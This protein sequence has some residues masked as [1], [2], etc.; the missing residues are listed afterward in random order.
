MAFRHGKGT[1]ILIGST[2]LSTYFRDTTQS[3]TVD[4]AE[5]TTYG[6]TG[7]AKTYVTGLADAT[8]SL[9]GLFDDTAGAADEVITTALASD[10]DIVFT[11]A[12]DGGLTVGRRCL[13][14]QSIQTKY[15]MT[16]P[17]A[18]VV[19]TSLDLQSD[20]ETIHGVVLAGLAAI[21]TTSNGTGV[22]GTA[23]TTKGG[24]ATLH[25]TT[26]TRNGAITV[27]VQHSADNA[28]YTDLATFTTVGTATTTSERLVVA[29][30]TTV[31]RYLRASFTVAGTTGSATIAVAFGRRY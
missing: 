12:Q 8:I 24:V 1:R 23:A 4:T 14:G 18:D 17:V 2:D 26:N 28:T 6:V 21:S 31:N 30:G 20:G 10:A 13:L 7:D 9:S 27:K 16:S 3:S 5:T 22:D 29:S 11:I 25:V 19:S 15:D